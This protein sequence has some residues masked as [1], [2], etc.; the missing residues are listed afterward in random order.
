VEALQG[1]SASTAGKANAI[2]D[3]SDG[4][5]VG[6]FGLVA[7]D[8]QNLLLIAGF[9]RQRERH[10]RENDYVVERDKKKATH[11]VFTFASYLRLVRKNTTGTG[12]YGSDLS[13][14]D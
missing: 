7:G 8:Q 13:L 5:H 11:E 12:G 3:L 14:A 10:A 9:D 6:K 2:A 4:A 1:H